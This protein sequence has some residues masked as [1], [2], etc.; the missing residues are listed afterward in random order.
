MDNQIRLEFWKKVG[1]VHPDVIIP[2]INS[3]FVNNLPKWPSL[4]QS[5]LTL[6][7]TNGNIIIAT[8]G[9]SNKFDHNLGHQ[10]LN[11]NGFEVE[12]YVETDEQIENPQN[13]YQFDIIYQMA[14]QITNGADIKS[15]LDKY[16][17]VTA[18]LYD[19]RVPMEFKNSEGRVGVMIGL[20]S[21]DVPDTLQLSLSQIKIVNVKLLTIKEL[22][23]ASA[24]GANGRENLKDLFSKG[25]N[26]VSNLT[27]ESVV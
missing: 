8:N 15:M 2:L 18:E 21:N 11:T 16:G 6:K 10:D 20:H 24:N 5:F 14:L 9:L 1:E 4:E 19:V 13:S 17:V 22:E 27:R 3:A 26:T 12:L 23:Y 7:K 25:S